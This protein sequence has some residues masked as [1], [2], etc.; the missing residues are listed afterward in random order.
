MRKDNLSK[1]RCKSSNN[2]K[3]YEKKGNT[4]QV[5]AIENHVSFC[6]LSSALTNQTDAMLVGIS[7]INSTNVSFMFTK[8][9]SYAKYESLSLHWTRE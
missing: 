1:V 4:A 2:M 3:Q 6:K 8:I 5:F 9:N 7:L